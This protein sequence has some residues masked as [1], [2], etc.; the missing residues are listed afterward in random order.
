MRKL[1]EIG[2]RC[3]QCDM[4]SRNSLVDYDKNDNEICRKPDIVHQFCKKYNRG[5]M[6]NILAR[7]LRHLI[8]R[9]SVEHDQDG[10][11]AQTHVGEGDLVKESERLLT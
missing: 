4:N 8:L 2:N 11:A 5:H 3:Q 7:L 10:V 6:H 1:A 9:K